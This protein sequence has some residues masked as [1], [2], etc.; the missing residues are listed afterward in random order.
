MKMLASE[1]MSLVLQVVPEQPTWFKAELLGAPDVNLGIR[2][3]VG[4][5][6]AA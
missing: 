5:P 1:V 4:C 3:T 6:F 2:P